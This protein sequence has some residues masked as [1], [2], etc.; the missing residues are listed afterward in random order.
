MKIRKMQKPD[1]YVNSFA[2]N[3]Y[4]VK[5]AICCKFSG[6]DRIKLFIKMN[7]G[8]YQGFYIGIVM[9]ALYVY[10]DPFYW[11]DFKKM[12]EELGIEPEWVE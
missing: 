6:Q 3:A 4:E 8:E 11:D 10:I 7:T 2:I 1:R 5:G 9:S 12:V